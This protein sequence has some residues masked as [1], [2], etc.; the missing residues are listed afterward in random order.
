M[1]RCLDSCL[2]LTFADSLC[3]PHI[4]KSK[5]VYADP[6]K[7]F[8]QKVYQELYEI[9]YVKKIYGVLLYSRIVEFFVGVL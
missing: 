1:R 7:L 9:L 5:G 6:I 4:K 2:L 8:F 3:F